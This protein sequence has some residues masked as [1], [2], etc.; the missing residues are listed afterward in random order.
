MIQL[1]SITECTNTYAR[2]CNAI[3]NNY[4]FQTPQFMPVGTKATVKTLDS[5][6]LDELNFPIILANTYHLY[7]R[8]GSKRIYEA[9]GLKKFMSYS[10]LFLTDSG[11]F[12]VYS[13]KHLRKIKEDGVEF[14][15]IIDG[16]KHFF[17]PTSV[18]NTQ[19]ELGADIMMAFDECPPGDCDWNYAKDSMEKTHRWANQCLEAKANTQNIALGPQNLFGI[20][21]GGIFDDLRLKSQEIIQSM[22]FDGYA[23]GG[24][25][26][27]ESQKDKKRVLKL[28]APGYREDKLRYLMGVGTPQDL[29][30]GV[31]NGI[32]LFDCVMPTRVARHGKLYTSQGAINIKNAKFR[33]MD[34]PVDSNCDCKLCSRYSA[35]YLHHLMRE[36]EWTGF[37]L[38][39]L[40]NLEFFQKFM[41]EMRF[42][43]KTGNLLDFLK[44]WRNIYPT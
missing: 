4:E 44:Y 8:P 14:R 9:G 20:I 13:L 23:V 2:V 28:L 42:S 32:D 37:R 16:S 11:G 40:H 15:S 30:L 12:Q 24:L 10:G 17:S 41:Q 29:M 43:I 21:Q 38:A 35:S 22:E 18:I 31:E 26:V 34:N 1:E 3:I 19:R 7:L 5:S 6:D 33:N 36:D 39:S 25:S 27:G